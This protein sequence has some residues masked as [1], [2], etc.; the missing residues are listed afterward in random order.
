MKLNLIET[1]DKTNIENTMKIITNKVA[2][3]SGED[4]RIIQV[5]IDLGLKNDNYPMKQ[6]TS[7]INV[8]VI[9]SE[10]PEI[11]KNI[12]LNSMSSYEVNERNGEIEV[13]LKNDPVEN[14]ILWTKQGNEN[15]VL[16][17]IYDKDIDLKGE[18]FIL[19]ENVTLQ[20]GKEIVADK[21]ELE[22]PE[23]VVNSTIEVVATNSENEIFKGK[24]NSGI[25]RKFNTEQ[26]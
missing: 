5:S 1:N 11:V 17:Y 10:K 9:N 12:N 3:I 8:P 19:E 24:L 4:K 21:T 26:N 18:K 13:L 23:E 25:D 6:I 20:N 16:T 2:K 14:N 7:K 22:V 15:I